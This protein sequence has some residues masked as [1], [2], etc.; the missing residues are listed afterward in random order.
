MD[1]ARQK[2]M[3]AGKE[4]SPAPF[5]PPASDTFQER[6]N[7]GASDNE[8]IFGRDTDSGH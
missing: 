4:P 8:S 5:P 3:L 6:D 7:V 1:R 2:A